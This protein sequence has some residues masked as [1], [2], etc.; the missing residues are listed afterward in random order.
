MFLFTSPEAVKTLS[1]CVLG[2]W[3][4]L[5]RHY[6]YRDS[7]QQNHWPLV[8]KSGCSFPI[9][10]PGLKYQPLTTQM[11][12][13]SARPLQ[14]T[15]EHKCSCDWK[16]HKNNKRCSTGFCPLGNSKGI[17]DMGREG[18]WK[19][20]HR[21]L[22]VSQAPSSSLTPSSA[23]SAVPASFSC[24]WST[25]PPRYWPPPTSTCVHLVWM[26]L[27]SNPTAV[28]PS[29]LQTEGR[30]PRCPSG[31]LLPPLVPVDSAL[32]CGPSAQHSCVFFE[33]NTTVFSTG[34]NDK[35]GGPHYILRWTSPQAIKE[36]HKPL[37]DWRYSYMQ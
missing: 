12:P 26:C 14:A 30:V 36:T 24:W 29:S 28:T 2:G 9:G 27:P 10:G 19:A 7:V 33:K 18:G 31:T 23:L 32:P 13:L 21:F 22:A 17:R 11:L 34:T 3:S 5:G 37:G 15:H 1:L 8:I 20:G 25:R 6:L 4:G 16:G 35:P